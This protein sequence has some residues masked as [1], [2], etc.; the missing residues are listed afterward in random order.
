MPV[1]RYLTSG[2]R[3]IAEWKHFGRRPCGNALGPDD[4]PYVSNHHAHAHKSRIT[5][6]RPTDGTVLETIDQALDGIKCIAVDASGT[7]YATSAKGHAVARYF[8]G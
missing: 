6:A 3:F 2:G 8:R 5:V 7:I 1:S 4:T